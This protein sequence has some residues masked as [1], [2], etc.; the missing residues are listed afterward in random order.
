MKSA[1]DIQNHWQIGEML[2]YIFLLNLSLF[3]HY[4]VLS[5]CKWIPRRI[6]PVAFGA[7]SPVLDA[8]GGR[9]PALLVG[10]VFV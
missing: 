5:C 2:F 7:Q 1:F 9:P 4:Q 6:L 3:Y 8:N 10:L